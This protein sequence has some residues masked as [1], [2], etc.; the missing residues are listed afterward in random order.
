MKILVR[1]HGPLATENWLNRPI[2]VET[3]SSLFLPDHFF[4]LEQSP[5]AYHS[6]GA[7]RDKITFVPLGAIKTGYSLKKGGGDESNPS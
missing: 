5:I 4:M 2:S 7:Y 3:P 1:Y 6:D